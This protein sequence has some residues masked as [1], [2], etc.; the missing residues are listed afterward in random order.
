MS[1]CR[2]AW[3]GIACMLFGSSW[4]HAQT[5]PGPPSTAE[6]QIVIRADNG[7][8][9]RAQV[10]VGGNTT[11]TDAEGRTT[12]HIAPGP[13][14]ITVVKEG[15]N[16]VT[17]SATAA[18]GPP[19]VIPIVLERQAAIEDHVTVSATRTDRRIEDQPMRVEVLDAEEIEEKQLMTPGDIVMMLNE[20]GGLRVQATS[21]S[22]GAASVRVQ[23]MRGR[24]T[25]F[26]SDGLPLFG[27]EVGGL[28]LLQIPPTDLGQ[29]EVIKGVASAL[30]G[31]GALGGVVDLI[32]RRPT[33]EPAREALV[34]RT[35]R[36]GTD[37]TLFAAQPLTERWSGTLLVG[38]H[39][40]Q[41]NDIDDDGW[42]DL[43]GYSRAIVRPR[44]FWSDGTGRTLF[45]TAG[46]MWEQ[47]RGGTVPSAVLS[48]TGA[49]YPESLD[50]TRFDGGLMAQAPVAQRYVL[51]AR[52]SA[53]RKDE[54]YLRGEVRE[55]DRQETFFG[56]LAMR[57]TAPRQTWVAGVAF[58]R[59]TLD[60]RDDP[61]FAYQY[62]VPGVFLQDDIEVQHWLALSVSGRFDS[63][64][65]FGT[66][67]S[68][69]FSVLAKKGMWTSRV[70]IGSG[71]FA[72]T[73][74]TEETEA[75]GLARLT[76]DAPLEAERGRSASLDVTRARGPL[77][78]TA[79]LFRYEVHDPAVVDRATYTLSTLSEP[80]INTG[81]ET[82][83]TIRHPP[84]SVT[85][86]YTF[87]HSREGAG[88][89]RADT[90]LTPRHSAGLVGMWESE[91]RGRIGVEAYF[92][93][94]QRL[95]D[96][97]Y[98]SQSEAYVLFG[99]LVERRFGRV[100]LFVNA[101]NLGGVRQ[102]RFDPLVRPFQ[103]ADGRWTVDAWAPLDGRVIN[104]GVRVAF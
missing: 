33:K 96:N 55:R 22:L 31:A 53:T 1:S 16:P 40:Q 10:T 77:S 101:E 18:A 100:R 27:A 80:T 39:W 88:A 83:A 42:A 6:I 8:I 95:D 85:A 84:F 17:V 66:F 26:L 97:P 56:E 11:E 71:F 63:H 5:L 98:R 46:A 29:V 102:T 62:N 94:Q 2:L 58:E 14:E 74:L 45:A 89:G 34:N 23:G 67:V 82:V 57:G 20:M 60:P 24:Y 99:G 25:R 104:G 7:P 54:A 48:P 35:S 9:L 43:A 73:A 15:F 52:V 75:A 72:P 59:S 19:Q 41:R 64:S 30:Y 4:T 81:L 91:E 70:S 36:G 12:L 78:L 79:T 49:P 76:V 86:T 65:T 38:G 37:A 28:G 103:A 61:G 50:T 51:T 21:P 90:P 69:R 44:A 92:T 68:P 93:G 47:R 87:V 32:S 13:V 3:L